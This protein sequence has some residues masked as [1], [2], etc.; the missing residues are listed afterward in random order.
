M[1]EAKQKRKGRKPGSKNKPK[2]TPAPEPDVDPF[3][4]P[5][6]HIEEYMDGEVS[7]AQKMQK[8][9]EKTPDPELSEEQK[10]DRAIDSLNALSDKK[11]VY[12]QF[13]DGTY[14]GKAIEVKESKP[15]K[16]KY[17]INEEPKGCP[18]CSSDNTPVITTKGASGGVKVTHRY[19]ECNNCEPS[20]KFRTSEPFE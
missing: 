16:S 11:I 18:L 10:W 2:V 20:Y 4:A 17:G 6:K 12:L 7:K 19:R 3:D 1:P 13:E 8:E 15:V 14:K 5:E 9:K